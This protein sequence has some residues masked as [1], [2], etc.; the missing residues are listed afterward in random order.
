MLIFYLSW[1][2]SFS[3]DVPSLGLDCRVCEPAHGGC[4]NPSEVP[5]H[6]GEHGLEQPEPVS[7]DSRGNHRGTAHLTPPGVSKRPYTSLPSLVCLL[8]SSYFKSS[9]PTLLCLYSKLLI[10]FYI[11]S[12][13]LPHSCQ[14]FSHHSDLIMSCSCLTSSVTLSAP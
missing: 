6:S 1:A 13:P 14:N 11:H 12:S 10:G 7:E 8:L 9:N 3:I 5:G 2:L 4:V